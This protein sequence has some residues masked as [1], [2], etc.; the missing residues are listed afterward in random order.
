MK[1]IIS[2]EVEVRADNLRENLYGQLD[3]AVNIKLC[4]LQKQYVLYEVI[5]YDVHAST[6]TIGNKTEYT[7]SVDMKLLV[8]PIHV[9]KGEG[10]IITTAI[11]DLIN[12]FDLSY[13]EIDDLNH[14]YNFKYL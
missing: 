14:N 13:D 1:T 12:E 2:I 5:T 4:D 6:L 10:K 8:S 7:L 9:E 3:S 11:Q